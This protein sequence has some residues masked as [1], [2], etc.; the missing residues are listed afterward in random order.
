MIHHVLA[1]CC[2]MNPVS[3]CQSGP[4]PALMRPL[5]YLAQPVYR[6]VVSVRNRRYDRGLGSVS[7]PVPVISVGNITVGGT[8]KSPIV[9]WIARLLVAAGHRPVIGMRGYKASANRASDEQMEYA[10]RISNVPVIA[11]PDRKAALAQFLADHNER[12]C[13]ILDDGFQHRQINRDLDLVLIDATR[14]LFDDALLPRG[15]LREPVDN[16]ARAD[17]VILT[18]ADL[19]LGQLIERLETGIRDCHGRA[20][21][22]TCRHAWEYLESAAERLE[23][24]W[25]AGRR[26][27][28]VCAIGSPQAFLSAIER[29]GAVIA[30]AIVRRDHANYDRTVLRRIA[31]RAAAVDAEAVLT[32]TKDWMKIQ[33]I[34]KEPPS[35]PVPVI[36]P[37]LAVELLSGEKELRQMILTTVGRPEHEHEA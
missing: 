17:A 28:A 21:I 31:A 30:D 7:L 13:V 12:D 2:S 8:G 26:V 14:P 10:R 11:D 23:L 32:T 15:W 9:A 6:G 1:R 20:P 27:L 22:A 16:L 24:T 3:H 34:V 29:H 4:L 36:H 19:A 25:L 5:G 18:H 35:F 33:Q 37:A